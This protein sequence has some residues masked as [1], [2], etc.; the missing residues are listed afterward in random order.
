LIQAASPAAPNSFGAAEVASD[1]LTTE[2]HY[3]SVAARIVSALSVGANLVLVTGDPPP[4][5]HIFS[6]AL[7]KAA[8]ARYTIVPV[9]C[10]SQ[11][12]IDEL[13]RT[14]SVVAALPAG[15]GITTVPETQEAAPALFVLDDLDG[16][17]APHIKNICEA[18]Q[19]GLRRGTAGVLLARTGFLSRLEEPS[20]Q[21]LKDASAAQFR[22]DEI[23]EDERIEFLR[24]QLALR[25]RQR[26]A[27]GIPTRVLRGVAALGGLLAACI[28]GFVLLQHVDIIGQPSP[29]LITTPEAGAPRSTA[30][31]MTSTIPEKAAT[32][33]A[34][35]PT[36][37]NVVPIETAQQKTRVPPTSPSVAT[38]APAQNPAPPEATPP[39]ASPGPT[40]NPA[41]PAASSRAPSA[42]PTQSAANQLPSA[43]DIAGLVTRGDDFLKAGDIA[44]A[45]LFYERAADAGDGGAALRLGATFD[46]GFL[47]RAGIRGPPGDSELAAS[48]YRRARDL[49][50]AAAGE[51]LKRL[52]PQ[53]PAERGSLSR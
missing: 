42:P 47:A 40:K 34:S 51:L 7:R 16:N 24:Y 46:P 14:G 30:R 41:G 33:S 39:G 15:G 28:G 10:G 36:V 31:Q 18:A 23:G 45:R 29:R 32:T 44:S 2:T 53:S 27:S 11:L 26:E 17:P 21:F 37:L 48:W 12:T 3:L 9:S 49:G 5:A 35:A 20:L 50:D 6:Q 22:F 38:L 52:D 4:D 8:D 43:A 1:Y 13:F 19:H 25:H